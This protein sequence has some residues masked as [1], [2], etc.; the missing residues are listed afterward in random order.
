[1]SVNVP[2]SE[3]RLRTTGG[4]PLKVTGRSGDFDEEGATARETY[5]LRSDQLLNFVTESFPLPYVWLGTIFYPRRRF[6]PG[7]PPLITRR[8]SWK[9]LTDAKPSDPFG[10]DSGA[11]DDTYEEN[12]EV[13]VEY[14]TSQANDEQPNPNDPETFLEVS[15]NAS[16][17]FLVTP[18]RGI[19]HWIP[20][21]PTVPAEPV[22]EADV[23]MKLTESQVEWS[24]RWSQIPFTF[25][26][27]TLMNRLRSTL[28][29][30]NS[31]AMPLFYGA[32]PETMLFLGYSLRK[33]FTWRSD[34]AGQ[35]P[36]MLEMKFLEKNFTSAEGTKVTHNHLYR[37][38]IGYQKLLLGEFGTTPLHAST[39][40]NQ[41]FAP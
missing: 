17:E 34:Y 7:L 13:T 29:M 15:A 20:E 31:V 33:Q 37:K 18:L 19:A 38:G 14:S 40:L 39:N 1:M 4:I 32:P 30:V 6:L 2:S 8:V 25:F 10:S 11:L 35:P 36:I 41:I 24:A 21:D 9:G 16:G 12:V 27:N 28:G 23:N 22:T 3:W 5:I 26:T